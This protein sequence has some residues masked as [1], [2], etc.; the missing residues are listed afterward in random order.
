MTQEEHL[1]QEDDRDWA[2]EN[3]REYERY[4]RM[5][6][7][8][9][10]RSRKKTFMLI[11]FFGATLAYYFIVTSGVLPEDLGQPLYLLWIFLMLSGGVFFFAWTPHN[12][13]ATRQNL[14]LAGLVIGG[15]TVLG[16]FFW[17]VF[18]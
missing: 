15:A 10:Q 8:E 6:Y 14:K 2:E 13:E 7:I 12:P 4:R 16:G 11:Y 17:L 9:E 18:L 3:R 1:A 5:Q